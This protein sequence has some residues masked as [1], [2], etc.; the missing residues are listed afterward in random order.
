MRTKLIIFLFIALCAVSC[1]NDKKET[2]NVDVNING[3]VQ[4]GPFISGSSITAYELSSSL[5]PTGRTFNVQITDN[6]GSFQLSNINMVS[7]FVS[8]RADGFYYN[9]ITGSQSVAPLT[10]YCLSDITNKTSINVNLLSHLEKPRIEYLISQGTA[11][12]DAKKQAEKEV[13]NIFNIHKDSIPESELLDLTK[14]GDDNAILLAV[15]LLLNGYKTEA[16]LTELLSAIS[17]DIRTDGVLTDSTLGNEILNDAKLLKLSEIRNNITS[18]WNVL[19][20]TDSISNFETYIT[21]FIDSTKFTFTNNITYPKSDVYGINV[22]NTTDSVLTANTYCSLAAFLPKGTSLIIKDDGNMGQMAYAAGSLNGWDDLGPD[23]SWVWR[24]F[25]S[26]TTGLIK[27]EVL[28][29]DNCTV[30]FYEDGSAVP[31]RIKRLYKK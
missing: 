20:I 21:K 25:S 22:L 31:T 4:K 18:R 11:F 15:S 23:S 14:S 17:M 3:Y 16:E 12:S 7:S 6:K 29:A 19:G 5:S 13:L 2:E 8:F 26:N 24:T 27:L 1:N 10:L 9:E 28:F 30:Y